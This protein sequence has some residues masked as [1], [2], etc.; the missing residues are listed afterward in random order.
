MSS[1]E[2][3]EWMIVDQVMDSSNFDFTLGG[4]LEDDVVDVEEVELGGNS[5]PPV[6]TNADVID[7]QDAVVEVG[8]NT[9]N[10][11]KRKV[12]PRAPKPK[13][14]PEKRYRSPY[15][16]HLNDIKEDENEE[17]SCKGPNENQIKLHSDQVK[18]DCYGKFQV[19]ESDETACMPSNSDLHEWGQSNLMDTIPRAGSSSSQAFSSRS[20]HP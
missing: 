8:Q 15:W 10:R 20:L 16:D 14:E 17:H 1:A 6:S 7:V 18:A 5:N 3:D 2:K 12:P 9:K 19:G 4:E 13:N 11:L